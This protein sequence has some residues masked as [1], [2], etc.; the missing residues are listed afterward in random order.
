[1]QSKIKIQNSKRSKERKNQ[2]EEADKIKE[3]RSVDEINKNVIDLEKDGG[4]MNS[5][6]HSLVS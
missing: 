3:L 4:K 5:S 6:H 1:V 2:K